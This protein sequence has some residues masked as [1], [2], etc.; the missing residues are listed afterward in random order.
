MHIV[1]CFAHFAV[2][3]RIELLVCLESDADKAESVLRPV[4][5]FLVVG[6]SLV[7]VSH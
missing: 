4:Y 5:R 7:I 6:Y 3:S 1:D 2:P